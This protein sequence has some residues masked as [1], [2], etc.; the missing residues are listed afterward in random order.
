MTRT[1]RLD[2]QI[3]SVGALLVIGG[4][5]IDPLSQQLVHYRVEVVPGPP[6]SATLPA[7]AEWT[8]GSQDTYVFG[9][10]LREMGTPRNT[11]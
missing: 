10:S 11:A 2:S 8:D 4:L 3:A 9:E 7:A 6:G 1:H 5:A